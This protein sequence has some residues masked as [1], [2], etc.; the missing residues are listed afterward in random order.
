MH[1]FIQK[2]FCKNS[3][4]TEEQPQAVTREQKLPLLHDT[5]NIRFFAYTDTLSIL[6][7][8]ADL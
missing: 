5:D 3:K 2:I 1:N 6:Q 4:D 7:E 8:N